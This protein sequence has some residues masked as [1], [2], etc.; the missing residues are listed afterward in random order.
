MCVF[1]KFQTPFFSFA[2][3]SR[4]WQDR[5]WNGPHAG[6]FLS[7]RIKW[8]SLV[9]MHLATASI[10]FTQLLGFWPPSAICAGLG[11]GQGEW[12]MCLVHRISGDAK[13]LSGQDKYFNAI[14]KK[15]QHQHKKIHNEQMIKFF[16]KNSMTD[17]SFCLKLQSG[18]S[19][20]CLLIFLSL[21][22]EEMRAAAGIKL[23]GINVIKQRNE[24]WTE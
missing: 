3:S 14:L 19:Q 12:A 10:L 18:L 7:R 1:K 23:T 16:N 6:F 20:H 21:K 24:M 5:K 13:K 4:L 8:G 22:S 11:W 17:I 2:L 15:N 9:Y